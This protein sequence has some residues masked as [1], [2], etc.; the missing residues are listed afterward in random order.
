[1]DKIGNNHGKSG[2]KNPDADKVSKGD[3]LGRVNNPVN[4]GT[5]N[6]NIPAQFLKVGI[7]EDVEQ[8]S[9]VTIVEAKRKRLGLQ[10]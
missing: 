1:M 2:L 8:E 3:F 9:V 10:N 7:G 4:D 6:S 5:G